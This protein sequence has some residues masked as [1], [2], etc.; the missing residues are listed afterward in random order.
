MVKHKTEL[1]SKWLLFRSHVWIL[2]SP[3]LWTLV[4]S[5][6]YHQKGMNFYM[7]TL[8]ELV[9]GPCQMHFSITIS[10]KSEGTI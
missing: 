4:M 10:P 5:F 6:L 7:N 1:E 8:P 3:W 2:V 9:D